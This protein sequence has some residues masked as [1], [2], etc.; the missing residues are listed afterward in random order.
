VETLKLTAAAARDL[1]NIYRHG[2]ERFGKIQADRY[3]D[4]LME[5]LDV[6]AANPRI[7][8]ERTEISPPVRIHPF[9]AHIIIYESI[10]LGAIIL[11]VRHRR[12]DWLASLFEAGTP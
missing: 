2:F 10:E 3:Y 5:T 12:E 4:M 1:S 8:R 11:R 7:A 9:V 6:I